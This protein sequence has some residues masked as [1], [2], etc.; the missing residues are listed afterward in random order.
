MRSTAAL[1]TKLTAKLLGWAERRETA[2]LAKR[3][4]RRGLAPL[5]VIG[6]GLNG[7]WLMSEGNATVYASLGGQ[8]M[9]GEISKKD[10]RNASEF[11][12]PLFELK[13]E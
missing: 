11:V 2:N 8:Q 12:N 9:Q 5:L 4:S 13:Q 3:S 7:A 1:K 6:A 10:R